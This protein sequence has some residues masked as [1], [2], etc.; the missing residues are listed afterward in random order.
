MSATFSCA[1][2]DPGD[3]PAMAALMHAVVQRF[4]LSDMDDAAGAAF[5]QGHGAGEFVEAMRD[6][7]F[8]FKAEAD[9]NV[10]GMIG[11]FGSTH[12]KYLF[13]DGAW[14]GRGIAR[15]LLRLAVTQMRAHGDPRTVTLNSSDYAVEAYRKLGFVQTDLRQQRDG[16]WFTPMALELTPPR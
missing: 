15:E 8:F 14:H 12:V 13:V 16:V 9:G 6:G 1:R 11:V 7:A 10:I 5:L 4:L 2:A 3:A